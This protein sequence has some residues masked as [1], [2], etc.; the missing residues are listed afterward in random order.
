MFLYF[1]ICEAMKILRKYGFIKLPTVIMSVL[2]VIAAIF[3]IPTAKH[4]LGMAALLAG[5][6]ALVILSEYLQAQRPALQPAKRTKPSS[7][8][9]IESKSSRLG[10]QGLKWFSWDAHVNV[11]LPESLAHMWGGSDPPTGDRKVEATFRF[12]GGGPATDY[13]RACDIKEPIAMI[14]VGTGTALVISHAP[15]MTWIT[16]NRG[17]CLVVALA[18]GELSDEVAL[19]IVTDAPDEAFLPAEFRFSTGDLALILQAA[20]DTFGSKHGYGHER[21]PLKPGSYR[22]SSAARNADGGAAFM[23]HRFMLDA[24]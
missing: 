8:A 5:G 6:L 15:L 21:I 17:F 7:A 19:Q 4:P 20:A 11:L 22:V 1:R 2:F 9:P 18:W 14:S 24:E 12:A 13:D 3:A 23:L 10:S 16:Q